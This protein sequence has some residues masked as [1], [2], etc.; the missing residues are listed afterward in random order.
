MN[1]FE[2]IND[3]KPSQ[4]KEEKKINNFNNSEEVSVDA[5]SKDTKKNNKKKRKS[6]KENIK[7]SFVIIAS[8][9]E[10]SSAEEVNL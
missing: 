1:Y 9:V 3:N 7:E 10:G 2:E 5:C 6:K 4:D 8:I